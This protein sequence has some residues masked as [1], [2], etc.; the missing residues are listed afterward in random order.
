MVLSVIVGASLS[1][2]LYTWNEMGRSFHRD[3][4]LHIAESGVEMTIYAL[5][6]QRADGVFPA[7]DF[8]GVIRSLSGLASVVNLAGNL[9]DANGESVGSYSTAVE[10]DATNPARA[11]VTSTGTVP[12]SDVF[13]QSRVHRTVR[14]VIQRKEFEAEV[15][16]AA[17]YTPSWVDTNGITEIHGPVVAGNEIR[18][19]GGGDPHL[20]VTQYPYDYWD[21]EAGEVTSAFGTC[22][23]G[24]NADADPD[25]DVVLP[26]DEFVLERFKEV[27][28]EQGYY[29][30]YEPR[31]SELPTR[32]YQPDGV[33]P[34]I[35]FITSSVHITG[36]YVIGGVIFVVGDIIGLPE[37]AE[38]GGND[39]I[40]GIIYTTGLFRTH[41]GGNKSINVN[42]GVYC[43]SANLQGHAVVEYNWEYFDALK[44]MALSSNK[45]RF[46]S[47]QEKI[48]EEGS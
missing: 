20:R 48:G 39:Q 3:S 46:V 12:P 10:F 5:N 21:E 31:Q 16:D 17:I 28:V 23:E 15:F 37:D 29:F 8:G 45:F 33:T 13:S 2:S 44:D 47:W 24:R 22:D 4:A 30:N 43:G 34:N 25:N 40:E 26:F 18:T 7:G 41:G 35:V 19:V 27:A 9:T 36:N 14:V 6:H 42:G 11:F 38:F 1:R 32:F